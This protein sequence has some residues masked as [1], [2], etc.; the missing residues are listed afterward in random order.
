MYINKV[1][2]TQ[3]EWIWTLEGVE[4]IILLEGK[5]SIISHSLTQIVYETK[6]IIRSST[7]YSNNAKTRRDSPLL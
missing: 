1:L 4:G 5:G 6:I 3:N 2:Y 7:M